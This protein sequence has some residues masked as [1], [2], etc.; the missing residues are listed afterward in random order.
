MVC[1]WPGSYHLY[2]DRAT[3][4][5]WDRVGLAP[6][7]AGPAGIRAAYAGCHS[8]AIA[9]DAENRDGAAALLRHLTSFEAQFGEARRGT[10]PCRASALASIRQEA[11]VDAAETRRWELLADA[12]TTMIIPPRFA[13]YPRC[14]DTIWR[15]IQDAMEGR[16]SPREAVARAGR[17]SSRSSA[18]RRPLNRDDRFPLFV[19]GRC[20]SPVRPVASGRERGTFRRGGCVRCAGG[21]GR[22]RSGSRR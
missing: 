7:P 19:N 2:K 22:R 15:G 5:V 21:S 1:D 8:F 3:C 13:A 11:H 4:A 20:W 17:R 9:K 18:S 12:E 14:E 10:I 16:C 6:L